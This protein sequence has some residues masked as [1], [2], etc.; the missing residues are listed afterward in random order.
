MTEP[1]RVEDRDFDA[2]VF[3][4]KRSQRYHRAR[5]GYYN[6]LNNLAA[7]AVIALSSFSVVSLIKAWP[8]AIATVSVLITIITILNTVYRT[9]SKADRHKQLAL[10]FLALDREMILSADQSEMAARAFQAKRLDIEAR[11]LPH[12]MIL[13]QIKHNEQCAAMGFYEDIYEVTRKQ[14]W[15]RHIRD[16][17]PEDIRR[18]AKELDNDQRV[19]AGPPR[20]LEVGPAAQ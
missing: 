19:K 17:H 4:V 1:G 16:I 12:L 6:A 14:R 15:F 11:E 9:S 7:V 8:W 2:I 10:D 3:H 5:Q 20:S 13:N 18:E